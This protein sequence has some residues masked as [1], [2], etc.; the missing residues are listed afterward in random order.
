[1]ICQSKKEISSIKGMMIWLYQLQRR[2]CMCLAI[3]CYNLWIWI[4]IFLMES[5]KWGQPLFLEIL[6]ASINALK[7]CWS[8]SQKNQSMG[9]LLQY[10]LLTH[11]NFSISARDKDWV[12][13][14]ILHYSG[15]KE[16]NKVA[17]AQYLSKYFF[18]KYEDE[19]IFSA[20]K[21]GF[22]VRTSVKPW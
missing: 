8:M 10:Q 5:P 20:S 6:Y 19:A 22:S 12:E 2:I 9:I 21:C 18:K 13:D 17:M 4:L 7:I 11:R 3:P 1:M 14:I 16:G 15:G